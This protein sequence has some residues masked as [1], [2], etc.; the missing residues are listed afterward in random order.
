MAFD[1]VQNTDMNL[2]LTGKAGTGKT[3]FLRKLRDVCS[4]RMVVVAP[5]GVAAMNAGGVTIHSFFQLSPEPYVPGY[6]KESKYSFNAE[7]LAI[8]RS[9]DLLVIDEISMVRADVLEAISATLCRIRRNNNPFG[10]VQLLMIGDLQQLAPVTTEADA[11]ILAPF[12]SSYFFF[13]CRALSK[14]SLCCIELKK[15]YRQTDSRFV[16]LL[17]AVRD[18]NVSVAVLNELNKRYIPDF[19]PPESQNYIRLTTHRQKAKDI[20]DQKLNSLS[21]RQR[22]YK[23]VVNGNFQQS[24]YP[25]EAELTLKPGAQVMFVKNDPSPSKQFYNGKIVTV[26]SLGVDFVKVVDSDGKYIQVDPLK[27]EN[28]KYVMNEDTKEIEE[29]TDGEFI[30]LPLQLAWAITI[31]KS[32]GLTFDR[33]MLDAAFAF[34]HGQ[35]YVALSRCRTLE[36]LVLTSKLPASAV[37]GER[38]VEAFSSSVHTPTYDEM[39]VLKKNYYVHLLM[40]QFNFSDMYFSLMTLVRLF[41]E[42]LSRTYRTNADELHQILDAVDSE[43][44]QIALKFQGQLQFLSQNQP[45]MIQDRIVKSA[46]Y[47]LP[48]L[49]YYEQSVVKLSSVT[50]INK[51]V[52]KK[53]ETALETFDT[54]VFVKIKTMENSANKFDISSYLKTKALASIGEQNGTGGSS[55]ANK[56]G[57]K[58][59]SKS[60][61]KEKLEAENSRYPLFYNAL[62]A[63]RAQQAKAFDKPAY[64]I[65]GQTLFVN[66]VNC[67]PRTADEVRNLSG[68]G[69]SKEM[70]IKDILELTNDDALFA[71]E[72]KE[73][74]SDNADVAPVRKRN[75]KLRSD[76]PIEDTRTLFL[77]GLSLSEIAEKIGYAVSTTSDMLYANIENGDLNPYHVVSK[78]EEQEISTAIKKLN[79]DK[80]KDLYEYFDGKYSYLKL[81]IVIRIL[82]KQE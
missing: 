67:R 23:A 22:T 9:L 21:T 48:K 46:G 47:F 32:Q 27:W 82:N 68:F 44:Q 62:R 8:I 45:E 74:A 4:K 69:P 70:Y 53:V 37:I 81:R 35:V 64:V 41:D 54:A 75:G 14:V 3:T 57:R 6:E 40:D 66:I 78:D 38:E 30:Q 60:K 43:I 55:K 80:A 71:K 15:V 7:K 73:Y 2:F 50:I 28:S 39:S 58:T 51:D 25:T 72:N 56:E 33:V 42:H 49:K 13:G 18:G 16:D 26:E 65:L 11:S 12:Y 76:N 31:H 5:T 19:N 24:S 1:M 10:G 61:S 34:A 79:T 20:N 17:N 29:V 52:A 36:G 77:Q 59:E 63:W